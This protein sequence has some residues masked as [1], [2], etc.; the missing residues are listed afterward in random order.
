MF[1]CIELNVPGTDI[2]ITPGCKVKLGR[3]ESEI[4]VCNYGWYCYAGN[5]PV[6]GWY[7]QSKNDPVKLKPIFRTDLDDIY[8]VSN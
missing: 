8:F 5:R 3:F 4:W 6:C 7:I 2:L 1:E